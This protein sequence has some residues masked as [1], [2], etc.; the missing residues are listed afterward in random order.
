MSN[1]KQI[2]YWNK[3]AGPKWVKIGD[4]M[5]ARFTAINDL[6]LTHAAAKPGESVLDVGCGTGTT[7]LPLA[8]AVLPGGHIT[9]IDVSAPMLE[10]ARTR[11]A[12]LPNVRYL[13]A[14][15][16][17]NDFEGQTFDLLAS[18]FGVMFFTEPVGAFKNLR[19]AMAHGGRLCFVC[20]A[21]LNDNPHWQI[22][23]DIVA[24]RLGQP[25]PRHKYAPGPLAF[26]DTAYL[27]SI[28]SESGFTDIRIAPTPVTII[29]ESLEDEARIGCFLGPAGALLDEKKADT[30]TRNVIRDDIAAAL[31]A[32]ETPDGMRLPAAVYL[33]TAAR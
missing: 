11:S 10:V 15:A 25:E 14:D 2:E 24:G 26:S 30:E 18:R 16:Q 31:K 4:A 33:V 3:I 27:E 1:E 19:N 32:F 28:L 20:W 8:A 23:F 12:A 6:L 7:A 9:G 21:P 13:Q 22:P 17:I 5:D 29:G